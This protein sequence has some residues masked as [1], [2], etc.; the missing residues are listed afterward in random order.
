MSYLISPCKPRIASFRLSLHGPQDVPSPKTSSV[1]PCR[2]SLCARPS[3][4]RDSTAQLSMLMNPG[5]T[6]RPAASI[7]RWPLAS[8]QSTDCRDPV[9]I[10]GDI[11]GEWLAAHA[12]VDRAAANDDVVCGSL[13]LGGLRPASLAALRRQPARR[14]HRQVH[15]QGEPAGRTEGLPFSIAGFSF[16]DP[17]GFCGI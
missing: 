16:Q 3:S 9:A 14:L 17:S 5:A 12:V 2:T 15:R 1:T 8:C 11:G 7:S 4:I 13:W 10:D 6:A